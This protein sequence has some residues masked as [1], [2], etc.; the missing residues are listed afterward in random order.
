MI[1]HPPAEKPLHTRTASTQGQHPAAVLP[2]PSPRSAVLQ[3]HRN[4]RWQ[5][6]AMVHNV[7]IVWTAENLQRSVEAGDRDIEI[8]AHL[9]MRNLSLVS[10][11]VP[12]K[13]GL[14]YHA[15]NAML[16]ASLGRLRSIRVRL[17]FVHPTWCPPASCAPRDHWLTMAC[18]STSTASV[19]NER[20]TAE[21]CL[22]W[23]CVPICTVGTRPPH[24]LL[25]CCRAREVQHMS[26]AP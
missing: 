6:E 3:R 18:Y 7:T 26:R 19:G 24:D 1:P 23:T 16:P 12:G 9:D 10:R 8:R 2:S 15:R 13:A 14:T 22:F 17:Y 11:A 4:G 5:T 20:P 25:A 21:G